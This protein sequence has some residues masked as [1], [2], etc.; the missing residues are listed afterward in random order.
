MDCECTSKS[1]STRSYIRYY[2]AFAGFF[3]IGFVGNDPAVM[4]YTWKQAEV[5]GPEVPEEAEARPGEVKPQTSAC[6]TWFSEKNMSNLSG[7]F[8]LVSKVQ[9]PSYE[10]VA[11]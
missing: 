4:V 11:L 3:S 6:S 8:Q 7:G 1:S 10:L 2:K 5:V 9:S